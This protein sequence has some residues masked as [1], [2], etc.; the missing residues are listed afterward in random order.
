MPNHVV[1]LF[2]AGA[3]ANALPV[4]GQFH[5]RLS[6]FVSAI[7]DDPDATPIDQDLMTG[8]M[9]L[10]KEIA[11]ETVDVFAK[12]LYFF[13]EDMTSFNKLKAL[14]SCFFTFEQATNPLDR[15]YSDLL[16]YFLVPHMGGLAELPERISFVSWNYDTQL[17]RAFYNILAGLPNPTNDPV[18][19][20]VMTQLHEKLVHLNGE[21]GTSV[22]GFTGQGLR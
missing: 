17:E 3:S 22:L 6:A 10:L 5:N 9:W 11:N 18:F 20:H 7:K 16:T 4:S 21:C 2:G 1:Y 13:R 15:R 19:K 8:F 14:L 12:T